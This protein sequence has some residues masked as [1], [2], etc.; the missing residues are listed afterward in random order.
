MFIIWRHVI[1]KNYLKS[2]R[3]RTR[4]CIKEIKKNHGILKKTILQTIVSNCLFVKSVK[5]SVVLEKLFFGLGVKQESDL[6]NCELLGRI[7]F[8]P[9]VDAIDGQAATTSQHTLSVIP[10]QCDLFVLE[11]HIRLGWLLRF[12]L[13]L[14]K[15]AVLIQLKS[16]RF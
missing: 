14:H 16:K 8:K 12:F 1:K 15:H 7:E 3:K 2:Y 10:V 9:G 13:V 6:L 11:D 5:T 4:F